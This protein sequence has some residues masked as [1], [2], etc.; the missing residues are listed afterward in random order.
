MKI[1]IEA[2]SLEELKSLLE[3]LTDKVPSARNSP[4]NCRIEALPLNTRTRNCLLAEG[5]E[6]L[7]H[8]ALMSEN[9][10]RMVPNLGMKARAD[11]RGVLQLIHPC[12]EGMKGA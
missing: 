1:V 10:L 12:N 3:Q 9:E 8:L 5:I 11:I 4:M 6:T 7:E 2:A